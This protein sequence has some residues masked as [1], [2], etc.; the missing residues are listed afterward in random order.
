MERICLCDVSLALVHTCFVCQTWQN[1]VRVRLACQLFGPKVRDYT[2]F[3]WER[4]T[5]SVLGARYS[6]CKPARQNELW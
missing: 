6:R 4:Y 2:A 1:A 5:L 3:W